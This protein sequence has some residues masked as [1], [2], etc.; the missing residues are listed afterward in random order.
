LR[1]TRLSIYEVVA[2]DD[3]EEGLAYKKELYNE[4]RLL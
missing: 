4:Y 1:R 2:P 3:E